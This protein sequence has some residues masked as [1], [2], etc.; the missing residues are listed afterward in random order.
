MELTRVR[1]STTLVTYR[2]G[3]TKLL[4]IILALID[5]GLGN[6]RLICMRAMSLVTVFYFRI[7]SI[8]KFLFLTKLPRRLRTRMIWPFIKSAS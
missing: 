3:L 4:S 1:V 6:T 8:E 5:D 7:I 2:Y